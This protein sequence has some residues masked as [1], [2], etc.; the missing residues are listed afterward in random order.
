MYKIGIEAGLPSTN[1]YFLFIY[2]QNA[3]TLHTFWIASAIATALFI[4]V[5]I[6]FTFKIAGPICRLKNHLQAIV[7][8]DNNRKLSFRKSD[9]FSDLPDYINRATE[10]LQ[11]ESKKQ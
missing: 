9:F 11:N 7:S 2:M 6:F 3:A 4:V 1:A 10:H 5:N 8:G